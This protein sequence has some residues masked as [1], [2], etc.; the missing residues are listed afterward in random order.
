MIAFCND[1]PTIER[2]HGMFV[3]TFKS[4]GEAVSVMITRNC[5]FALGRGATRES[6]QAFEDDKVV[7]FS[8]A[9]E[10]RRK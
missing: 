7:Q 10:R 2:Q 3:L 4:G 1:P 9:K 8:D 5:L 6:V